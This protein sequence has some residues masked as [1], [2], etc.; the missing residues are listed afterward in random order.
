MAKPV[1]ALDNIIFGFS[2]KTED[3]HYTVLE[4]PTEASK[5]AVHFEFDS[6]W[7]SVTYPNCTNKVGYHQEPL[8][9]N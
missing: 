9:N 8:K 3:Y 6:P 7:L 1:I 5:L 2:E 4:L